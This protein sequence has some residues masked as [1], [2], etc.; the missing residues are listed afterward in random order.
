MTLY[1]WSQ[2]ASSDATADPTINWAE[3]QAPSSVN[4]SAR[5]MMAATAKYRDDISGAVVTG[6]TSTAY[7]VASYEVFDTL[8]H[9]GGQMIAFTPHTTN[10]A[11]VTLNVDSLGARPLRSA[12][13]TELLAGTIVQGTPYVAVYNNSDGA[14][15]LRGFYG[16]PYIIPIGAGMDFYG[17]TAPNS[18]FAFPY[19]QA[20]SRTTY[21]TLFS[22]FGTTYGTGDGSTTFNIP[23]LRGRVRAAMDNMG[24][25]GAGRL[26][27]A[28]GGLDGTI[29][30]AA[31]SSATHALTLGELPGGITSA[32][33][34]QAISV[35]TTVAGIPYNVQRGD[36]STNSGG[37]YGPG[38]LVTI[39]LGSIA[40]T[41]NNSI[42]VTSNNTGGAAHS[43]VQPTFNCNHII[44]II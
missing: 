14:F 7:T 12:P 33:A 11:T 32:N 23:D 8:A 13:N 42:S 17:S 2:T 10:G 35:T 43:I 21:A 29:L 24:G 30:G 20:I 34:S 4:D 3:G 41:G 1:K 36:I 5:A 16:N 6:G 39:P 19:G 25:T 9:L 18:S 15:Y 31:S 22:M 44:R 38:S 40:S 28:S 26:T 27:S 37:Y